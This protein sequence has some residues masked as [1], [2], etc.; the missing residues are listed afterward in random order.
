MLSDES[1]EKQ[2][3]TLSNGYESI[4][5]SLTYGKEKQWPE[6]AIIAG[7][8]RGWRQIISLFWHYRF[9]PSREKWW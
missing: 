3:L 5:D 6:P 2:T 4:R 8:A 1:S 9:I 7:C